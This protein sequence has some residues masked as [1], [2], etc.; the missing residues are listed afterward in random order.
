[1]I[2]PALRLLTYYRLAIE[3]IKDGQAITSYTRWVDAVEVKGGENR[4]VCV[5]FSPRF[6]RIWV[7]SRKCLL[8]YVAQKPGNVGL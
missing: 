8:E 3:E 6:E 4:E 7:E 5:T 1:M 2:K